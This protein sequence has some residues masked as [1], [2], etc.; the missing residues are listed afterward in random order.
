MASKTR[1]PEDWISF[2]LTIIDY[3]DARPNWNAV[4]ADTQAY[5]SGKFVYVI[6]LTIHDFEATR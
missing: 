4:A 6:P 5:K 1:S 2:L 3:T